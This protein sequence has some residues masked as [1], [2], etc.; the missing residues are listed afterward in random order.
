MR[1]LNTS[2]SVNVMVFMTNQSDHTTGLTGATLTITASKNGGAFGSISPTVTERGSGWY[3][4]ALT[5]SHTDTAG[6]LVLH[7]TATNA[8]PLDLLL[9]VGF[10]STMLDA[11]NG[12]ETGYTVRQALRILMAALGGRV[13]GAGT[14][15]EVFTDA[16]ATKPRI[17]ATVDSNGN[18]T[19]VTLDAT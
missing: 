4:I 6:D 15:T 12:V 8:D 18:R 16:T 19:A 3:S 13:S 9:N 17:T 10:S 5:T 11:S 14:G 7:A 2:T 1:L